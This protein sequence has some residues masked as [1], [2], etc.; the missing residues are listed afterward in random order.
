MHKIVPIADRTCC[1]D[2]PVALGPK[3]GVMQ[4][5]I[6]S[7]LVRCGDTLGHTE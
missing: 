2:G 6:R 7:Q 1:M 5:H 4:N 3:L